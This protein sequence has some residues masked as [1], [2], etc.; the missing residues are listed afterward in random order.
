MHLD[1]KVSLK[2]FHTFGMEVQARYFVEPHTRE[3]ILTLL[4]YRSMI[5]MPFL[6]LGCG[7][8][9]LFTK[10]FNGL[11]IR[12]NSKGIEYKEQDDGTVKVT[13]EAGENWDEFVQYCVAQGW[14]GLENL[15]LIP[16]TVGAAPVQ[17]IGA[18]GVEVKD[19]VES[20]HFVEI[21]T[22][23]ERRFN[24]EQ[25]CFGYRDSIFKNSLKGKVIILDVTFH[26]HKALPGGISGTY[27]LKL[28]Y[29]QI[30][31]ELRLKNIGHPGM[32][33]VREAVCSIRRRKLPDPVEIGNA[34]SFFKN[35]LVQ[36]ERKDHL[37]ELYPM[38]PWYP[39]QKDK[40]QPGE[41]TENKGRVK[42]PAAWLIEQCGWKGYRD[43]DAGVHPHQSLVLV[44]YGN[45]TGM[46]ILDLMNRIISS[47]YSR[48][49]IT[50]EPE[51]NIL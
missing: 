20:V 27:S 19:L 6:I 38:M 35:P 41:D 12:I 18:Y 40:Q 5:R 31:E 47:V 11:V 13:A 10:N 21:D 44:N 2:P 14:A 28:D 50:L 26:L 39:E 8:N 32:A 15:S 29:G 42:V 23:I 36:N 16:G 45:A 3:E 30:R 17:D 4:N 24:R 37:L 9:I 25:C 46:Q 51:V 48:F 1:Q 7:S 33:E 43:G 49:G 22:G 34:G